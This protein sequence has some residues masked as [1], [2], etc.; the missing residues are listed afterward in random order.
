MNLNKLTEKAREA[1]FAAKELAEQANHSADR[2]RAPACRRWSNS[3]D[4][5]VP[6]V[7]RKM[8]VDPRRV[9]ADAR[10]ALGRRPQVHGGSEAE[11]SPGS[12]RSSTWRRPK[13]AG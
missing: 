9:A 2:A 6:E 12:R 1:L 8:N 13:R 11:L 4:G 10:A 7:L 5:V 3:A